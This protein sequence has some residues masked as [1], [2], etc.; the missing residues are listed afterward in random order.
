MEPLPA[1]LQ[2]ALNEYS[3]IVEDW[4]RGTV[5]PEEGRA[6]LESLVAVDG[7]GAWWWIDPRDGLWRRNTGHGWEL[8]DPYTFKET[9]TKEA[10]APQR[11]DE[12]GDEIAGA[13]E[14]PRG[15]ERRGTTTPKLK[16]GGV[17]GGIVLIAGG[18]AMG[19][20]VPA[21]A[22]WGAVGVGGAVLFAGC[23][24]LIHQLAEAAVTSSRRQQPGAER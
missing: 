2:N 9:E 12:A 14:K 8:A 15:V 10:E 19:G 24:R 22:V 5:T 7:A 3:R 6:Q 4:Q 18:V 11:E 23:A 17:V 1:P 13:A 16:L 21:E 20:S